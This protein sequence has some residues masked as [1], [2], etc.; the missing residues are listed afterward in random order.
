M[1]NPSR[2]TLLRLTAEVK[3]ITRRLANEANPY[4][5][6]TGT[7]ELEGCVVPVRVEKQERDQTERQGEFCILFVVDHP[8]V[9]E[10]SKWNR[11]YEYPSGIP[12]G[13]FQPDV[14]D[15][16]EVYGK[17]KMCMLILGWCG[18]TYSDRGEQTFG[19]ILG[20]VTWSRACVL[21]SRHLCWRW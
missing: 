16:E 14:D 17:A 8:S 7:V 9:G 18:L 2:F 11:P 5:S 12:W 15:Y 19:L 13:S 10:T 3:G 4:G 20:T 1:P 6:G 21:K